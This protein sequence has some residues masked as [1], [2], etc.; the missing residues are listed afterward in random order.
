M[1]NILIADNNIEYA[2]N[3]MNYI[4][5]DNNIIRVCNIAKDGQ[6]T[7]D[8]LNDENNIDIIIL[9]YQM[10][11]YNGEEILEKIENKD[12]YV[13]SFIVISGEIERVIKMRQCNLVHSILLKTS[14]MEDIKNKIWQLVEY[15]E[16]IRKNEIID[17]KILN[18]ILYLGYDISHK[19]TQ[20][21]I[22]AI[23]LIYESGEYDIFNLKEDVYPIVAKKYNKTLHNIKCDINKANDCMYKVCKKERV[24]KYFKFFDDTKPTVKN[25]IYT[26]LNKILK[27]SNIEKEKI[28]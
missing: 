1:L 11:I 24:R 20:Y 10:P 28:G 9:D 3:L 13:D 25:V 12:K 23:L 4:N 21:L 8:I 5:E 6:K 19:G 16:F 2:I 14:S 7:I 15:K 27:D 26:I 22:D 17:K 18:E